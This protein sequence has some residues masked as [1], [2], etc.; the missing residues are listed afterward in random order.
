MYKMLTVLELSPISGT[1]IP[2]LFW[3]ADLESDFRLW[4][5]LVVNLL[6]SNWK[7]I[8]R[9]YVKQKR[10]PVKAYVPW[11][12]TAK[13]QCGISTLTS[14]RRLRLLHLATIICV[15]VCID[16]QIQIYTEYPETLMSN[17]PESFSFLVISLIFIQVFLNVF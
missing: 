7:R 14:I 11:C 2:R 15:F 6:Y 3:I 12:N 16:N 17:Q 5:R 10:Q 4:I 8:Q 9:W 1:M 13:R